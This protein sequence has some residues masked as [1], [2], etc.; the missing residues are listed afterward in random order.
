MGIWV[1]LLVWGNFPCLGLDFWFPEFCVCFVCLGG[2]KLV[3]LEFSGL[4]DL[5]FGGFGTLWCSL[6]L[7]L[8]KAGVWM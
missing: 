6:L 7:G 8:Y 5:G 1:K 2:L 3:F 4:I